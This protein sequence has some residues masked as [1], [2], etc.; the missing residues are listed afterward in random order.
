[1]AQIIRRSK[2]NQVKPFDLTSL[3]NVELQKMFMSVP[4]KSLTEWMNYYF[5]KEK[6]EI[7]KIISEVQTYRT[8]SQIAPL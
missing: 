3:N 2:K 6:H 5:A 8:S 1:M 7:C 4:V